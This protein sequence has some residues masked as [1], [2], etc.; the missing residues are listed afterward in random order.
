MKRQIILLFLGLPILCYSQA[1]STTVTELRGVPTLS[2]RFQERETPVINNITQVIGSTVSFFSN[3]YFVSSVCTE[4]VAPSVASPGW[5]ITCGSRACQA[6]GYAGGY[7][8]EMQLPQ[9][10]L[11]C[12]Q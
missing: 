8:S 3:Q 1:D 4:S 10:I 11:L 5:V 6:S 12:F 2:L 7:V 9:V